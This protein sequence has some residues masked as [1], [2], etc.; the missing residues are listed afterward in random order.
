VKVDERE[1][2]E[3]LQPDE[4]AKAC[5]GKLHPKA[6]EG[7]LL[8][9]DKEYWHA[10]EALE[11]AWLDEP[12]PARHLYKGILQA[13]V[14]YLQVQRGNSMGAM[15]MHRRSQLWLTPWPDHCRT[16]DVGQLK[17]D[18]KIV[19]GVVRRLGPDGLEEFDQNLLK[20]IRRVPAG[21]EREGD[22]Q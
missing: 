19:I 13:G 18:L 22:I 10:H 3:V 20:P 9:D 4:L 15:K 2:F 7:I 17:A 21:T 16:V 12:G 6:E 1:Q 8:F 14:A 11:E 5:R